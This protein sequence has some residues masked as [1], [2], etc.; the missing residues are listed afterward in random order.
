MN[1]IDKFLSFW[2]LEEIP[3]ENKIKKKIALHKKTWLSYGAEV[4]WGWKDGVLAG[5]L[6]KASLEKET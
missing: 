5:S 1:K 3:I 6:G 4:E 2:K